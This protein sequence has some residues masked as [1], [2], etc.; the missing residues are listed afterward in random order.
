[1]GFRSKHFQL[2]TVRG[3]KVID[4]HCKIPD[5]LFIAG[6]IQQWHGS[7]AILKYRHIWMNQENYLGLSAASKGIVYQKAFIYKKDCLSS[8]YFEGTLPLPA[9]SGILI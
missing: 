4:T 5:P 7:D 2:F 3:D 6:Q 9:T 1:M 8:L